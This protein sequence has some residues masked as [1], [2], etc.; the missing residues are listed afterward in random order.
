[1]MVKGSKLISATMA[2]ILLY[3]TVPFSYILE[4]FIYG[5]A[6]GYMEVIGA[7]LIVTTNVLIGVLKGTKTIGWK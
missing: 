7:V 3:I 2:G 4:Y 6:I 1:M 5:K